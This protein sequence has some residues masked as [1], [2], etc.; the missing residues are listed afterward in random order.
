MV[1]SLPLNTIN[2]I[3]ALAPAKNPF[4]FTMPSPTVPGIGTIMSDR[5][6]NPLVGRDGMFR[7]LGATGFGGGALV[8]AEQI[9]A[10]L[11]PQPTA[12][13]AQ[14]PTVAAPAS[15]PA[16]TAQ[17]PTQLAPLPDRPVSPYDNYAPVKQD[18]ASA[19]TKEV[20]D[21]QTGYTREKT[22]LTDAASETA[23]PEN[24]YK[25]SL[26]FKRLK[27]KLGA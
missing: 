16:P 1:S 5:Y 25:R 21:I 9:L 4:G 2:A 10:A 24:L 8:S 11:K 7:S 20:K 6:G 26:G 13:T 19:G 22:I 15:T 23:A 14:T 27:N 17:A 18:V 12:P 3:G